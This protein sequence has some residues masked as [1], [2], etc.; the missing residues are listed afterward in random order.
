MIFHKI[1]HLLIG[2]PVFVSSQYL[3]MV[4]VT[5]IINS[6]SPT[7]TIIRCQLL[8]DLTKL[9]KNQHD[10]IIVR[11]GKIDKNVN[12]H[13]FVRDTI[14]VPNVYNFIQESLIY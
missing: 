5:I 9:D 2:R 8:C 11:R 1:I 10:K 3:Q 14:I 6:L 12:K 4:T 13:Q 7:F